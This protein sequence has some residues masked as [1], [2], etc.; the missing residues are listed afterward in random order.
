LET[1]MPL[2]KKRTAQHRR[3]QQQQYPHLSDIVRPIAS[4]CEVVPNCFEL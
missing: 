1:E 4:T 2:E 3:K